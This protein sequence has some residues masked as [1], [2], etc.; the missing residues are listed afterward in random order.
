MSELAH[1]GAMRNA[2]AEFF[3]MRLSDDDVAPLVAFL[4]S[5]DEPVGPPR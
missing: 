3:A 4:L 2:P 5:L 1:R